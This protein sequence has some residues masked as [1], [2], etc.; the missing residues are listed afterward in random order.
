MKSFVSFR[1]GSNPN[2][3]FMRHSAGNRSKL[4]NKSRGSFIGMF[5]A[6]HI[7]SLAGSSFGRTLEVLG[8]IPG[9]L[10][11]KHLDRE[12][13]GPS[14]CGKDP[15]QAEPHHRRERAHTCKPQVEE[16]RGDEELVCHSLPQRQPCKSLL[17]L[18]RAHTDLERALLDGADRL[19]QVGHLARLRDRGVDVLRVQPSRLG[20]P[21]RP[22]LEVGA[23][24][25]L[26]ELVD[27]GLCEL[28]DVELGVEALADAVD[29][30]ER[31]EDEG[32]RRG[33]A[34]DLLLRQ[35][36]Q[37]RSKRRLDVGGGLAHLDVLEGADE[38]PRQLLHREAI[39]SFGQHS[40]Q[41]KRIH[42][43][44]ARGVQ[45]DLR[46]ER[47]ATEHSEARLLEARGDVGLQLVHHAA[48][49]VHQLPLLVD[50]QVARVRVTMEVPRL[51]NLSEE[52]ICRA[53]RQLLL[54]EPL[55]LHPRDVGQLERGDELHR[56]DARC[57]R[58]PIDIRHL[59]VVD[60]ELLELVG[61][62]LPVAALQ[63]VVDLLVEELGGLVVDVRVRAVGAV[64]LRVEFVE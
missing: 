15:R 12:S 29:R 59:D 22:L 55:S 19:L 31:A 62:A 8:D 43:S 9:S 30:R 52:R 63:L 57:G 4:D 41:F 1:S 33:E 18:E 25:R 27:E 45:L 39:R 37:V 36:L 7:F 16:E 49:V 13:G 3:S 17:V 20:Q 2:T 21:P 51:Q 26:R 10:F 5:A 6:S 35:G 48:V 56:E 32:E 42:Q 61:E 54:V 50:T 64:R 24:V 60:A 23:L 28:G 11:I 46:D 38:V 44:L 47:S 14:L 53:L 34:E 40:H 58:L